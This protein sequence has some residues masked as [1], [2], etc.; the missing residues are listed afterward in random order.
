MA[1]HG[2]NIRKR[3]DGRWEAR[4][5][6]SYNN[7]GKA[8]YRSVYGHSYEEVKKKR[9]QIFDLK[10]VKTTKEITFAQITELWLNHK[11]ESVKPS[12][13]NQ[14]YNQC[15]IHLLPTLRNRKFSAITSNDLNI[16]LK[17]KEA[18]GYSKRTL[19]MIRTILKMIILYAQRNQIPCE[20]F[21]DLYMP[22]RPAKNVEAFTI[23]EQKIISE[24]LFQ[25]H[26]P[27]SLAVLVSMYCGLRIGEICALQWKD[28]NFRT[29]TIT[30]SKTLLRIQNK[31]S[32]A[33]AR[34]EITMQNP[35]TQTS[36]R[37]VPIP[38]FLIQ[39]LNTYKT[40][41]PSVYVITGTDHPMEPRQCLRKF[42][43]LT[44]DLHVS[45]Y[46]FHAC[47]HTYATRC[48]ELGIDAKILSEML[49][50][51]SVKTTLDRYVHPSIDI[52]KQQ[53][54]KL[55]VLTN[56]QNNSEESR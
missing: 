7:D 37:I 38:D 40:D 50:H 56:K 30:I 36:C 25:H 24:Y 3:N 8:V 49:G 20:S 17:Q 55:R 52:K 6:S 35:K 39:V 44:G 4:Y 2:E 41:N 26:S 27:Y 15:H 10:S 13:F 31:S 43:K 32:D 42:K 29:E 19:I 5:I 47:R 34:T 18:D 54:N 48:I 12:T 51:T 1:R 16:L 21:D 53:V 22:K 11:K 33:K 45:D 28:I 46:S 9:D 14:Y 23:K